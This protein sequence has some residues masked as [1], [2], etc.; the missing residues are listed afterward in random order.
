MLFYAHFEG[1]GWLCKP[2]LT[3][4]F[5]MDHFILYVSWNLKPLVVPLLVENSMGYSA[6]VKSVTL[7]CNLNFSI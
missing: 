1:I 7:C 5:H 6:T 2:I 4:N 3:C